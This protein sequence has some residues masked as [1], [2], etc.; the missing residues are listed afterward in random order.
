M[1]STQN[2]K[3]NFPELHKKDKHLARLVQQVSVLV[4]PFNSHSDGNIES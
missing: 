1:S 4:S 3:L 2:R